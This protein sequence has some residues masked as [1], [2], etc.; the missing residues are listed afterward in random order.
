MALIASVVPDRAGDRTLDYEVPP[1]LS[2]AA[3]PGARVRVSVRNRE[4]PGT[5]V[6]VRE[7]QPD[8]PL[9]PILGVIGEAPLVQ[10][11]LMEMARWLADYYCCPMDLALATVLPQAV[12]SGAVPPKSALHVTLLKAP[13]N[14]E[15]AKLAKR[16]PRQA[17]ALRIVASEI[18]P[19][20]LAS[21][22]AKSGIGAATF[23][24]LAQTG[25]LR[26]SS[27]QVTRDPFAND[28]YLP[29]FDLPLNPSQQH[30]LEAITEAMETCHPPQP[31]LLHG[32]TGSG[33]TEVYLQAIRK[34]LDAGR[35]ALVLVPEISL[36]PQT[37]ERFK[38]RF[39]DRQRAIAV[40]HSH[41]SAGE[42]RDEWHRIH[43]GEATVVIGARS[44]VFA[45]LNNLGVL[46]VDEEH[47][48]SYKQE[49]SPRYH[50]R[51]VAVLRA[52]M[53]RCVVLLGTA[54]PSLES[55]HNTVTGKYRKL[56]LPERVDDR[57]MPL[58]RVLDMRRGKRDGDPILSP[59]LAR[60][61]EG[62]LTRS[63]QTILFL[64]RR[65]FSTSLQ[66][67]A[68]GDVSMCPNCSVALTFHRDAGSLAC[69]ICGCSRKAPKTCTACGDPS[70]RH[71]GI[72]TQKV[73][74]A[75][76]RLFPK[77]RIARMDA[78][79]MSRKDAYR[80]T[81]GAFQKGE[82]D[83]LVG[84]QMIA[85]GLDFP[86]VTLVGIINADIGLHI[87]DFRAGERTFQLLTQVAGRAGR[88]DLEGEVLVQT[89]TPFSPSIQFAKLHDF[90]GFAEQELDFREKFGFPPYARMVL[91]TLRSVSQ[92]RADFCA[93][94][95][96]KKLKDN[97][98]SGAICGESSPAPLAK[99]KAHHRFQISLRGPS[100][101]AL[102]RHV[103]TTLGILTMPED[104]FVAVDVDPIN[105][106]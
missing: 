16:A 83:I 96:A 88:G 44:A 102:A 73:E 71:S 27:Q 55:W 50:A 84:T 35:S 65:G 18:H 58:M 87:P 74:D 81:L 70:L 94:T 93:L 99:A 41:L 1:G 54:T 11:S 95:L 24:A 80:T 103:H 28:T 43:R 30:A 49:E 64:N 15:A 92:Q 66:C 4:I 17:E 72:G 56:E 9:K 29:T 13:S 98:P 69:H 51:D 3:A 10:P 34:A 2:H 31:I 67:S 76:R 101:R 86:N 60:A 6:D 21:L 36:T 23:R 38:A 42:R 100:S 53:E 77:A 61:I 57:K 47:E 79:A 14:E 48:T 22:V 105:L 75:V 8:R 104:V 63:E 82:T 59:A 78:D 7:E 91:I 39:A 40:L 90:P 33:K 68:C 46:I 45:P 26:I 19:L 52:R 12:R 37:V 5:V 62:R 89:F 97:L 32:V 106:L 20:P 85:K 25:W